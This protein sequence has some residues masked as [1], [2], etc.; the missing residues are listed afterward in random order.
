MIQSH[1]VQVLPDGK[2][3]LY[4]PHSQETTESMKELGTNGYIWNIQRA[5]GICYALYYHV[6]APEFITPSDQINRYAERFSHCQ[7]YRAVNSAYFKKFASDPCINNDDINWLLN[8]N[9]SVTN[10]SAMAGTMTLKTPDLEKNNREVQML[11][12]E[13]QFNELK[14]DDDIVMTDL[15]EGDIDMIDA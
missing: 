1:T 4:Q 14:L 8:S 11:G 10:R 9:N 13:R 7:Q 3:Q 12:L 2:Y 6:K 5:P 15:D